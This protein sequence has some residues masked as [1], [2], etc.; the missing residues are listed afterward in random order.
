MVPGAEQV[1]GQ[2]LALVQEPVQQHEEQE[3]VRALALAQRHEEQAPQSRHHNQ[4][5]Q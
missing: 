1:L 4:R 3:P 5:R 2:Q